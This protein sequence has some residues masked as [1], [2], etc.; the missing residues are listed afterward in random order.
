MSGFTVDVGITDVTNANTL[1]ANTWSQPG[2]A[3]NKTVIHPN[4][5]SSRTVSGN[6][7]ALVQ[8]ALPVR[9][10]Q[11]QVF[12]V[13]IPDSF[14]NSI[15]QNAVGATSKTGWLTGWGI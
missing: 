13:C 7:V 3:L 1:N 12:P 10:F 8:L 11:N 5:F 4:Y 2:L 9:I 15:L 6:N 14:V